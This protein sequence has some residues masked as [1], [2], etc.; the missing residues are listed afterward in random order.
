M[1]LWRREHPSSTKLYRLPQ[2]ARK[3]KILNGL[4][5]HEIK[6]FRAKA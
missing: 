4:E 3:Y 2:A 6:R 1:I 5:L